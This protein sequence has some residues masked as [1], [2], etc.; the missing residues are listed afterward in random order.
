MFV[1]IMF[2][3]AVLPISG[4]MSQHAHIHG[5]CVTAEVRDHESGGNDTNVVGEVPI[6]DIHCG[7]GALIPVTSGTALIPVTSG[8]ILNTPR[9][10]TSDGHQ[11]VTGDVYILTLLSIFLLILLFYLFIFFCYLILSFDFYMCSCTWGQTS[12]CKW[13]HYIQY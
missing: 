5:T 7:S 10:L 12:T 6:D 11:I 3:F 2:A 4:D 1:Y 9:S 13:Q 8:S